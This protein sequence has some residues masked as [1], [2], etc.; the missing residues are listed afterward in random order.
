MESTSTRRTFL[1]A[2][3]LT[4]ASYNRVLGA[5]DRIGVGFIGFGLIGKQHVARFQEVR[6]RRSGRPVRCLQAPPGGRPRIHGEPPRQGLQRL[7]QDV[8]E[9][10]H[11]G[12]RHR[13]ARPLARAAHHHGLRRR[14]G[15]LRRK[16]AYRVHRRRQVDGPGRAQVQ[17]HRR[18]GHP[19]PS[20]SGVAAAKKVIESGSLGKIHSVRMRVL[21]Q[22]LSGLRQ[23]PGRRIRPPASIT[24]CGSARRPSGPTRRTAACTISAGSGT[25][26]AGR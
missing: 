18:R 19:A 26:P 13:H 22:H 11:R 21:P 12:R 23:N 10:G 9:Q 17:A 20:Q 14:Q 3:A 24:T 25:T 5:N 15:R 2:T 8:R 7:S 16:A 6:R 4:A 1:G